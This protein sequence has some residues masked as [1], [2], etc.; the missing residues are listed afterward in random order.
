M[1]MRAQTAG[2][3]HGIP[4][5]VDG[6]AQR[7]TF[8]HAEARIGLGTGV[9]HA[10]SMFAGATGRRAMT[11]TVT[12]TTASASYLERTRSPARPAPGEHLAGPAAQACIEA[13]GRNHCFS[14]SAPCTYQWTRVSYRRIRSRE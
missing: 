12:Q 10:F 11:R 7:C 2:R 4:V 1:G 14:D 3:A 6:H 13:K 9:L 5:V 8:D